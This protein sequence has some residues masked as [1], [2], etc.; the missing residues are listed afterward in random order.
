MSHSVIRHYYGALTT[1]ERL[2]SFASVRRNPRRSSSSALAKARGRHVDGIRRTCFPRSGKIP[3]RHP[4]RRTMEKMNIR[5]Y[6][7]CV[8]SL[9]LSLARSSSPPMR[10]VA[11]LRRGSVYFCLFSSHVAYPAL[12]RLLHFLEH[13]RLEMPENKGGGGDK[14][15]RRAS[16]R[17][18]LEMLAQT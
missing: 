9:S 15:S 5:S 13:N 12:I 18:K 8:L 6:L 4:D 3:Q 7:G 17:E 11:T 10:L 16:L 2:R 1:I 14:R